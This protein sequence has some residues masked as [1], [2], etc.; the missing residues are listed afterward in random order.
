MEPSGKASA[1]T[2]SSGSPQEY[3]LKQGKA[4]RTMGQS[5]VPA[6]RGAGRFSSSATAQCPSCTAGHCRSVRRGHPSQGHSAGPACSQQREGTVRTKPL[7]AISEVFQRPSWCHASLKP[8]SKAK[9][10]SKSIKQPT[11]YK[12][13]QQ[14]AVASRLVSLAPSPPESV[15]LLTDLWSQETRGA[16]GGGRGPYMMYTFSACEKWKT[17]LVLGQTTLSSWRIDS[18]EL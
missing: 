5:R 7:T 3:I 14:K 4:A 8:L 15:S 12:P 18:R 10:L 13:T 9:V 16:G 1:E 17:S 6:G 11:G 2:Q